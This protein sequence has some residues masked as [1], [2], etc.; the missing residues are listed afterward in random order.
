[1][2]RNRL[3]PN[4]IRDGLGVRQ[5]ELCGCGIVDENVESAKSLDGLVN[6]LLAAFKSQDV[7]LDEGCACRCLFMTIARDDYYR[8]A[9]VKKT[10]SDGGTDTSGTSSDASAATREPFG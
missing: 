9:S 2:G 4:G 1:M 7:T 5:N 8:S 6:E 10:L 3:L